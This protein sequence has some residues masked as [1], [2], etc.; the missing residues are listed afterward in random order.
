MTKKH[1]ESGFTLIELMTVVAI[2]GT[3]IAIALPRLEKAKIQAKAVSVLADVRVLQEAIANYAADGKPMGCG[4]QSDC[5]PIAEDLVPY[6]PP[7]FLQKAQ[8]AAVGGSWERESQGLLIRYSVYRGG[9]NLHATSRSAPGAPEIQI[10]AAG[11][12]EVF[13]LRALKPMLTG[14]VVTMN[15]EAL[16]T[17][18]YDYAAQMSV[19]ELK[20]I[21]TELAATGQSPTADKATGGAM[22]T[23]EYIALLKA[24]IARPKVPHQPEANFTYRFSL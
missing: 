17:A 24:D 21:E 6:L 9:G 4:S 13:T 23:Q 22:T 11:L 7:G 8:R 10:Q 14:G 5:H 12:E 18:R 16:E 2:I 1:S 15:S 20:K 3:V 19:D